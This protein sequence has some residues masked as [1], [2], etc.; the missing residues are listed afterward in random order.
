MPLPDLGREL[1][2]HAP[3]AS[4]ALRARVEAIP[5]RVA[6]PRPLPRR[7][8]AL[9]AA[10]AALLLVAAVAASVELTRSSSR[11]GAAPVGTTAASKAYGGAQRE[12]APA[13]AASA[14]SSRLEN[15]DAYLR[16]RVADR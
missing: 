11:R 10:A 16:L 5:E 13:P 1:R 14:Q 4:P 3:A 12:F 9:A 7:R 2:A 6:A 15:V 8:L